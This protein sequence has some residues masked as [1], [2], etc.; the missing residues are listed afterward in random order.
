MTI[1]SVDFFHRWLRQV[2][3]Y[4]CSGTKTYQVA[5]AA[6]FIPFF[7]LALYGKKV[8]IITVLVF[9]LKTPQYNWPPP[10]WTCLPWYQSVQSADSFL[11]HGQQPLKKKLCKKV[12]KIS[13]EKFC[14]CDGF[15]KECKGGDRQTHTQT[16]IAEYSLYSPC[17]QFSEKAENKKTVKLLFL[18]L[19]KI[20]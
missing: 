17:D 14:F 18:D 19:T 13:I 7:F 3:L 20:S 16:Y 15:P 10:A 11:G 9:F 1:F 12:A 5:S 4:F 6:T 2:F 8:I